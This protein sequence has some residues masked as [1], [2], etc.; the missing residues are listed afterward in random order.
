[1]T[2][3]TLSRRTLLQGS[4]VAMAFNPASRSWAATLE[5]G[6]VPLPPLEGA[7]LMDAASLTAAAEDFG[8]I[9]H[10]T[11][12]AVL[13][14]GS[15]G[16]IVAMVRFARRQ[17]LH[18]AAARGLGESH[19]TYGQSQ[20]PAGIVIAMSALSTIHEIGESSAWVDAGV[21]WRQLLE[22]TLPSGRSPPTLTDYVELSIGGTLSVGGIGGQAF[23]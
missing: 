6:S 23:R 7:L 13:V 1:M 15:V 8:H 12:Q 3:R 21:R 16:D 19:S 17:G 2:G 22:A 11:P 10:R 5:P 20:V 18:I 4:L 9:V 14:P